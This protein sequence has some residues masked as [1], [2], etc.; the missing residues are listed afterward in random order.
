MT[1][2]TMTSEE[3]L[4]LLSPEVIKAATVAFLGDNAEDFMREMM[5]EAGEMIEKI[6][7]ISDKYEAPARL[8]ILTVTAPLATLVIEGL[9]DVENDDISAKLS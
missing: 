3:L 5:G 7:A 2:K 9:T 6:H 8:T 1:R 4:R